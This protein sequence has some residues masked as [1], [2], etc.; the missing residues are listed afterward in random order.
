M[1]DKSNLSGIPSVDAV[2]D[3][4]DERGLSTIQPRPITVRLVRALLEAERRAMTV[5]YTHLRAHET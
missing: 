5:S 4:L 3:H 1:T 2:L